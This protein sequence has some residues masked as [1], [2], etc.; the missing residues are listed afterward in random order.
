MDIFFSNLLLLPLDRVTR[1]KVMSFVSVASDSDLANF[2]V[3]AGHEIVD[4]LRDDMFSFL[5]AMD[6]DTFRRIQPLLLF[7]KFDQKTAERHIARLLRETDET[8]QDIC[9]FESTGLRRRISLDPIR[10]M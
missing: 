7:A 6:N 4:I 5:L 2:V 3:Q 1:A 10:R 8:G 9:D